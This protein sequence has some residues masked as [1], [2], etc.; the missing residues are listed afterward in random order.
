M[1]G[2]TA[3]SGTCMKLFPDKMKQHEAAAEC[4]T[5][6]GGHLARPVTGG[7]NKFILEVAGA[8]ML[9]AIWFS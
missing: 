7:R 3:H 6:P 4:A 2:W 8:E 9:V 5:F 1:S